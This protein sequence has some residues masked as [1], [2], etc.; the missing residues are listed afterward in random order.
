MLGYNDLLSR[1]S[2]DMNTTWEPIIKK[3][4]FKNK[5]EYELR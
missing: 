3:V 5:S 4:K 1:Q 2:I